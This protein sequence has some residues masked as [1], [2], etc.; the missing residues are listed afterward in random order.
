MVAH[1]Q[2]AGH[3]AAGSKHVRISDESNLNVHIRLMGS[4]PGVDVSLGG[5]MVLYQ[6]LA[7]CRKP[8]LHLC[9]A[10]CFAFRCCCTH[11]KPSHHLSAHGQIASHGITGFEHLPASD[12][13]MLLV[14]DLLTVPAFSSAYS[15]ASPLSTAFFLSVYRLNA[16]FSSAFFS[17]AYL[18][19]FAHTSAP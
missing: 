4:V 9:H 7:W 6:Y 3:I 19:A 16:G 2:I 17:F 14:Y 10:L 13:I 15:L 11:G 1:G 18:L 8:P 5:Q 12:D